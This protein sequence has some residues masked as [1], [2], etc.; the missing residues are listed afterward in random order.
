[1]NSDTLIYLSLI[2]TVIFAAVFSLVMVKNRRDAMASLHK[3]KGVVQE[4]S[5]R[6]ETLRRRF[7]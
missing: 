5:P 1:M 6:K 4:L 2:I 7:R 3:V